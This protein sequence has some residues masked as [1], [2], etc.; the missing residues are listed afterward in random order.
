MEF[1]ELGHKPGTPRGIIETM[2]WAILGRGRPL[3]MRIG[4]AKAR[5]DHLEW[6]RWTRVLLHAD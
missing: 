5:T 1:M 6:T 4:G 2:V 3:A